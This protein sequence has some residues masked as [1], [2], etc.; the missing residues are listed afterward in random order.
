L[1]HKKIPQGTVNLPFHE[2]LFV[3]RLTGTCLWWTSLFSF[4]IGLMNSAFNPRNCAEL[5]MM[6]MK[7]V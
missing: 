4:T 7:K 1:T 6:R 3:K 5:S 2:V